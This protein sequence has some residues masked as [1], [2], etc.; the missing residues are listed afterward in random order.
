[1]KKNYFA[2]ICLLTIGT[3]AYSQ[4]TV[5]QAG[6]TESGNRSIYSMSKDKAVIYEAPEPKINYSPEELKERTSISMYKNAPIPASN[7]QNSGNSNTNNP[8]GE[9]DKILSIEKNPK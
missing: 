9:K 2:L 8:V 3:F 6:S 5:P 4:S 1:M 7:P